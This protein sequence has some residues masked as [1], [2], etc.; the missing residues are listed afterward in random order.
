MDTT[1]KP[2]MVNA[3]PHYTG[4]PTGVEAIEIIE[5][6]PYPNLGNVIKYAWRVSWGSKHDDIEDLKKVVWY[7]Q[8]EVAR[9]EAL[10][11]KKLLKTVP[12]PFDPPSWLLEMLP[13]PSSLYKGMSPAE[14]EEHRAMVIS[15]AMGVFPAAKK[16]TSKTQEFVEPAPLTLAR[17]T[18]RTIDPSLQAVKK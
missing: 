9:R 10:Q 7:A 12:T 11:A 16:P 13:A 1:D 18:Q 14:E 8:R 2:D 17:R 3:P 4:H 15:L 5:C 6:N